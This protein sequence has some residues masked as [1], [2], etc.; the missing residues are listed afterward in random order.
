M[1]FYFQSPAPDVIV[2]SLASGSSANAML[3]QGGGTSLL[4]DAGV[5][6]RSLSAMMAKRGI[7]DGKLDAILLTHEHTDHSIGAG[8]IARRTGAPIVGNCATLQ[9]CA[10]RDELGFSSLE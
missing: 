5:G 3:V 2:H 1:T 7:V 8:P 6:V 4:I 9:V 10:E